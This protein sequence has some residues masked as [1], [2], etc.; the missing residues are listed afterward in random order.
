M[1]TIIIYTDGSCLGNGTRYAKGGIGVYF[2][3][4]DPRN[5]SEKLDV[6]RKQTNNVAE[7]SA[8]IRAIQILNESNNK[9][10]DKQENI[11]ICTDSI[12]VQKGITQW[13]KN[14]KKNEWKT[15]KGTLV[16]NKELWEQLD[17]LKNES[18]HKIEFEYV[19]GHNGVKGNEEAD[20]LA[21]N[22]AL[23]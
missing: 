8:V 15:S 9:S 16:E 11:K 12:Y 6:N 17:L 13:I 1:K 7:L 19:P 14:W 3:E 21:K 18:S 2:G 20:S 23:L 5:I 10:D 22:G 4:S